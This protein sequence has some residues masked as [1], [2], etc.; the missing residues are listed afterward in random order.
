M[1]TGILRIGRNA[2]TTDLTRS[3]KEQKTYI[4]REQTGDCFSLIDHVNVGIPPYLQKKNQPTPFR[5]S[6]LYVLRTPSLP[7]TYGE[8]LRSVEHAASGSPQAPYLSVRASTEKKGAG[9]KGDDRAIKPH[10]VYTNDQT[11]KKEERRRAH[12]RRHRNYLSIHLFPFTGQSRRSSI[13]Q[14]QQQ[15]VYIPILPSSLAP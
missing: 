12:Q 7:P 4:Y 10:A 5:K 2:R 9:Q 6:P 14:Q 11:E 13:R 15:P 1:E 3:S 8:P